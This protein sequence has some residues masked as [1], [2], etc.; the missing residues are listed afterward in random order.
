MRVQINFS[1]IRVNNFQTLLLA[2][3]L[4]GKGE[5]P[6]FTDNMIYLS[7]GVERCAYVR[8]K[9]RDRQTEGGGP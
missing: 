9:I 7:P 1:P 3:A 2:T 6:A 5:W 8:Q 4:D